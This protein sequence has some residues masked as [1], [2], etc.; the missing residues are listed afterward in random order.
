MSFK[1]LDKE[2]LTKLHNVELE[3]LKEFDRVCQKNNLTYFAVGGT[4]IGTIRHEG[5]IPWDD[6]IDLGMPRKDYDKFIEIANKELN[7]NFFV[8]S[9]YDYKN[10][11]VSFTK[12]RK[13]NTLADEKTTV[14]I[15]YPKGIFIDIFP[16]DNT[17]T[18]Q[19]F[20][21]KVKCNII[22][23]MAE[24]TLYKW[25]VKKI[26]EIRRKNLCRFF[27]LFSNK[28]LKKAQNILMTSNNNKECKYLVSYCGSYSL[29]KET[30]LKDMILP[31]KRKKF[32]NIEIFVPN[33]YHSYLTNIYGDYMQMP[34]KD[35]RVNHSMLE[36]S[37]DVVKD[38]GEITNEKKE[39][40]SNQK[41]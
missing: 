7:N 1:E 4:L 37:F 20:W 22:K 29:Y 13:K 12:I 31:V 36:I 5:F 33:D 26:N 6:D 39:K 34:P 11:W 10:S 24:A 2:T 8:Q 27:A 15:D 30:N 28:F 35:K 40:G 23:S 3:I 25:Q 19:G 18:N 14:H 16:F 38:K 9:G 32:E 17:P 21:F 41:K